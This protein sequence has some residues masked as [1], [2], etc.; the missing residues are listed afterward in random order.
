MLISCP[1]CKTVYMV[2]S[3]EISNDGCKMFCSK[4]GEHFVCHRG[5][6]LIE[7]FAD[8]EEAFL[9][10]GE[11]A[12]GY[13]LF[14]GKNAVKSTRRAMQIN[15]ILSVVVALFVLFS[16]LLM[17]YEIVRIAP[18]TEHVYS[19]FGIESLYHGKGLEF[20][21]ISRREYVEN[22]I[23]KIEITG[24][25]Y[26]TGKYEVIVP[27]INLQIVN[28]KGETVL[29]EEHEIELNR[30]EADNVLAFK[31]ITINPTPYSKSFYLTFSE[32][33]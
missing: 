2:T 33:N 1:K 16:L 19:F 14:S 5:D 7:N 8:I 18:F 26:N 25:I 32:N 4:C 23:S 28:K 24:Q 31:I 27:N 3:E 12:E 10:Y 20:I 22:N 21:N 13:N 11:N 17:R 29:W 15:L 9:Q 30:L 6:A